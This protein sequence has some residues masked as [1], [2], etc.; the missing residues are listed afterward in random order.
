MRQRLDKWL[1]FARLCKSRTLAQKLVAAGKVRINRERENSASH[2][3]KIGDTLTVTLES[4]VRVL[5]II[6]T[7]TRRGPASEAQQL[8]EDLA[9]P[10]APGKPAATLVFDPGGR[11]D[12]RDRRR[13][14]ALKRADPGDA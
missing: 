12:K 6:D 2:L 5:R 10:E 1:W 4:G 13:L 7:G 3:V 8:Y 14:T 9:P 11:P